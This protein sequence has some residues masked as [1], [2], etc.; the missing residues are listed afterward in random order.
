MR[1]AVFLDRDGV[2]IR[3]TGYVSDPRCVELLPGVGEA[4]RELQKSRWPLIVVTNQS[5]I[6]RGIFNHKDHLMVRR[7]MESLLALEGVRLDL[8]LYCPHAPED[9]CHCRK[10]R[11]GLVLRASQKMRLDLSGS[12]VVGDKMSD[13]ELAWNVGAKGILVGGGQGT[14]AGPVILAAD[15]LE[16]AEVILGQRS[17]HFLPG[18]P[19]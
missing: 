4:L 14:P 7:R 5:G 16:A 10:P 12:F 6:G 13:V 19:A 9:Q 2:I 1:G 3:D 18:G 8:Y 11:P 17:P 15:L